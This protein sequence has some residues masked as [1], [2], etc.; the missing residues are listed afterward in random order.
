MEIRYDHAASETTFWD[1]VATFRTFRKFNDDNKLR[2]HY[3]IRWN[4]SALKWDTLQIGRLTY[5]I[6][7]RCADSTV[8]F[9]N[10]ELE[11]FR[12]SIKIIFSYTKQENTIRTKMLMT[13]GSWEN[14]QRIVTTGDKYGRLVNITS[15]YWD[16]TSN[17]WHDNIRDSISYLRLNRFVDFLF[18]YRNDK[19]V[20]ERR[21]HFVCYNGRPVPEVDSIETWYEAGKRWTTYNIKQRAFED[22]RILK[23]FSCDEIR[24]PINGI[25]VP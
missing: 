5:D 15:G 4:S 13:N 7:G 16:K 14:V 3:S 23:E 12:D 10:N 21:S 17:I 25:Q 6:S 9:F 22:N 1:S 24:L 19:W 18:N 11:L 8:S 20:N 2:E